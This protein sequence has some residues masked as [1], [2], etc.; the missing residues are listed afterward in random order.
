MAKSR[1]S[2]RR[3]PA[4]RSRFGGPPQPEG[5]GGPEDVAPTAPVWVRWVLPLTIAAVTFVAFAPALKNDFVN[6]DD[7][8]VLLENHSFRGLGAEQL[9][10]MFT[11]DRMGHY[12]PLTWMSFAVDY[13]IWGIDDAFG[14]HLTNMILHAL[15]AVLFYFLAVRLLA[16]AMSERHGRHGVALRAG[17]ALAA[18]VFA[19]HPLRVE[20]V[21]WVTERRDVLSVSFLIPCVLCYIR[22][23]SGR[24]RRRHWYAA[25]VALML[26]SLLSKAWGI[27]LPAVLIVLDIY[28]LRRIR[29]TWKEL[30]SPTA[31]RLLLDK[32]PFA[33]LAAWAAYK[34]AGAQSTAVETMKSL[35]EHGVAQ[36]VAQAFYG[37]A[38]YVWKTILPIGL[39]PLYE[40]P[41]KMN[42]FEPRF[43]VAVIVVM[44]SIAALLTFRRRWP[45]GP[46]LLAVYVITLL[47]VL[48]FTQSGPQL[49]ADRYSYVS[50][51]A[52]ALLVGAGGLWC[53]RSFSGGRLRRA[54][55]GLI[56]GAAVAVI[57]TLAV[58][59]WRQALV[60]RTS[61]SLWEYTLTICPDS[62]Y[63]HYNLG[64]DLAN[65]EDFDRAI[66]EFNET[67]RLKPRHAG[68]LG[69]LGKALHEQG[70]TE[71][72][73]ENYTAALKIRA[74]MP[75]IHRWLGSALE[76]VGRTD[77][78]AKHFSEALRFDPDS[79]KAHSALGIMLVQQ[80]K[81]EASLA[82]LTEAVK[83]NPDNANI[84]YNLGLAL[85]KLGRVGQATQH[86]AESVRLGPDNFEAQCCLA[87][88]LAMQGQADRA[89]AHYVAALR[90][91]PDS[92]DAHGKV[93]DLLARQGKI[94]DAV[95]H[96]R[97]ALRSSP[98]RMGLANN[99]AWL[100]A[101]S[102][103]PRIR[104][105]AEAVRLAEG[106]C[107]A[108]DFREPTFLN[109][110]AAAYAEAGRFDEAIQTLKR[111][112]PYASAT[113]NQELMN[114]LE[115][116]LEL[117]EARRRP[118]PD[119]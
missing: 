33:A 92:A 79:A 38:F 105:V 82:H 24:A 106:A 71:E 11:A 97:E 114:D 16:L 100:L 59:T 87:A 93:A 69:S 31:R 85:A 57:V 1:N 66:E 80:G 2:R 52:L 60:W 12:H 19:V 77:E 32:I 99:L 7:E 22:Y 84:R 51:M 6:W 91:K 115:R 56:A 73:I 46:A 113:Q 118:G 50:C 67:L 96:Y 41:A 17:A 65:H 104:D 83:S 61:R 117:Y 39:A 88:A 44:V 27:T 29:A 116:R 101:T 62:C 119:G 47:P 110:L 53:G 109:T 37:L 68:A 5:P 49:V 95:G 81:I 3:R 45:A 102:P 42:P 15:N 63:A 86:L 43:V 21:A 55:L 58:A 25:S 23:V 20:S 18:L 30:F 78:A 8:Q 90:L 98:D 4:P 76:E 36:R 74:N 28:P 72:A 70:K 9:K 89:L 10:W 112:I 14:F 75:K 108:T 64:V 111:I 13:L 34:A 26:L 40:I 48:G 35:A 54:A 103:D 107:R 94:E